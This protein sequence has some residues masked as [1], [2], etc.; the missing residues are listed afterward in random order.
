MAW[1][2]SVRYSAALASAAAAWLARICSSSS[3]SSPAPAPRRRGRRAGPRRR[4]RDERDDE[5]GAGVVLA[6]GRGEGVDGPAAELVELHRRR[7]VAGPG[8][9]GT[10]LEGHERLAAA[11]QQRRRRRRGRR[12]GRRPRAAPRRARRRRRATTTSTRLV[13]SSAASRRFWRSPR[14][15]SRAWRMAVAACSPSARASST[16]AALKIRSRAVSMSTRM[17]RGSPSTI[18]G[19]LRHVFSPH[20]SIEARTSGGQALVGERLLHAPRRGAGSPGRSGS[21]PGGRRRPRRARR[22][23]PSLP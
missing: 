5:P 9:G 13:S 23:W 15:Y 1:R 16:S 19:T 21:R 7:L 10:G 14:R 12:T 11:Q 4:R 17:P 18:S 20:C 6:D 2:S 3:S 22:G 8:R